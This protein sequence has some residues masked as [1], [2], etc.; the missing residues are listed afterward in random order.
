MKR[1]SAA[2]SY[3]LRL[4]VTG[5]TQRSQEA[6]VSIREI[7]E[8]FLKGRYALEIVD[9]YE[10]AKRAGEDQIVASPTLIKLSPGP[11]RR[12]VGNL[13]DRKRVLAGLELPI[14]EVMDDSKIKTTTSY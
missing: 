1:G 9:I 12:F 11:I 4:Y 6:M 10:N 7:C 5:M 3:E 8:E 2:P 13:S 14:E